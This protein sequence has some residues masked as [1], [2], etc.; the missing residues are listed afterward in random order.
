MGS[1]ATFDGSSDDLYGSTGE[2]Q[3]PRRSRWILKV[4][5]GSKGRPGGQDVV[6]GDPMGSLGWFDGS[7]DDLYFLGIFI[8]DLYF[9]SGWVQGG[10]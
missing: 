10:T 9:S 8:Y 1:T 2:L 5:R 4:P 7:S 6:L 3:G